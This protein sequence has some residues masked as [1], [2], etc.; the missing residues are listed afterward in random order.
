MN[1]DNL[2]YCGF[3]IYFDPT[4]GSRYENKNGVLFPVDEDLVEIEASYVEEKMRKRHKEKGA[5][6]RNV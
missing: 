3:G 1:K 5:L 2:V 6:N 4:T